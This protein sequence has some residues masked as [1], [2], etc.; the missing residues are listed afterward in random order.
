MNP[1]NTSILWRGG[2]S[3]GNQDDDFT[4]VVMRCAG[5][6][7]RFVHEETPQLDY[8]VVDVPVRPVRFNWGHDKTCA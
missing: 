4:H 2:S 6:A 5:G 3:A 7:F 1:V 8:D